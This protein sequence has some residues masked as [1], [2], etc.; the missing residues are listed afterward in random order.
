MTQISQLMPRNRIQFIC[1]P[2]PCL[3][4]ENP[5]HNHFL[6]LLVPEITIERSLSRWCESSLPVISGAGSPLGNRIH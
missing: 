3:I 4:R 6:S 2:N 1:C 5:W